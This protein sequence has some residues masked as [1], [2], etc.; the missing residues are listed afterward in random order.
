MKTLM[1]FIMNPLIILVIAFVFLLGMYAGM[2]YVMVT[3]FG[4]LKP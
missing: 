3:C 4:N 1:R 2:I